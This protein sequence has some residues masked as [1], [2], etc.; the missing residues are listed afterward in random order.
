MVYNL[1]NLL[2]TIGNLFSN[3]S[4][5]RVSVLCMLMLEKRKLDFIKRQT[6]YDHYDQIA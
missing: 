6:F 3:Y 4:V 1:Y 5:A 2:A